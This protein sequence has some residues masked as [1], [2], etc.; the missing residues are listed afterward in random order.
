M[1]MVALNFVSP[2]A[3]AGPLLR[4][5][6]VSLSCASV[7]SVQVVGF[8]EQRTSTAPPAFPVAGLLETPHTTCFEET[9]SSTGFENRTVRDGFFRPGF[10]R[11]AATLGS[12]LLMRV[13]SM[14]IRTLPTS[15]S[16]AQDSTIEAILVPDAPASTR[17]TSPRRLHRGAHR[18]RQGAGSGHVFR[19]YPV[20]WGL[21]GSQFGNH[22]KSGKLHS[23]RSYPSSPRLSVWP[24]VSGP[25]PT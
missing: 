10:S 18:S 17:S 12:R 15:I 5:V 11:W 4:I 7:A 16:K 20:K 3:P 25:S 21:A 2:F 1:S 6:I 19:F 23:P 24:V 14:K 13:T 22:G 8:R 9:D